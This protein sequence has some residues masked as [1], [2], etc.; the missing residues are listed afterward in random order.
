M[1]EIENDVIQNIILS[2]FCQNLFNVLLEIIFAFILYTMLQDKRVWDEAQKIGLKN[3][4]SE[5]AKNIPV[6]VGVDS[7]DPN[8]IKR[9]Y[10]H[11]L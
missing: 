6:G 3:M 2:D 4:I 9:C 1:K 7:S 8:D 10:E 5:F 11:F